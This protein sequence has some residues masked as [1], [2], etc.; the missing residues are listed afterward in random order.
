MVDDRLLEFKPF[1]AK[2]IRK[3]GQGLEWFVEEEYLTGELL[4]VSQSEITT[5]SQACEELYAMLE[6]AA[7]EVISKRRWRELGIPANAVRIIEH[8]WENRQRLPLLYGRFDLAGVIDGSSPKLIEFNAD[9]ATI[10][11]ETIDIQRAQLERAGLA[12]ERQFNDLFAH[13]QKNLIR[14]RELNP[15]RASEMLITSLGHQEDQLNAYV[16]ADAAHQCGFYTQVIPLEDIMF[17]PDDGIFVEM[18]PGEYQP[19]DFLF[20]LVPWEFLALQEPKLLDILTQLCLHDKA[21]ILNPA[22]S[23]LFQSKAILKVLWEMYPGHPYLLRTSDHTDEFR[24]QAYVSK[25]IFGREGENIQIIDDTGRA[26][27]KNHGDFGQFPRIHQAYTPLPQD[28]DGDIYQAGIYYTGQAS[29]LSF[30]R[31]DGLIIDADA[32]F[33][34]HYLVD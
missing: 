6:R 13:L 3:V 4:G 12:K 5:Y 34:G 19:F 7:Q 9:T 21:V 20:K 22:Y 24:K 26:V 15:Q 16:L 32:E 25:V 14:L 23:M 29:A 2:E 8:S 33:I 17:S 11:P 28:S 27:A 31:R 1:S 10:L 30:R 18:E